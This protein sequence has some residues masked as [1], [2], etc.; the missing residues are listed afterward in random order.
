M[1]PLTDV[2]GEYDGTIFYNVWGGFWDKPAF[3][4]LGFK[5]CV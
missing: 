3:N 2:K 5:A 4:A 1:C